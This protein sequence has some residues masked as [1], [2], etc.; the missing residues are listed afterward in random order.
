MNPNR[1][2]NFCASPASAGFAGRPGNRQPMQNQ[3]AIIG[4]IGHTPCCSDV[5]A[6]QNNVPCCSDVISG[7]I[8]IG[9]GSQDCNKETVLSGLPIAMAYVPWQSYGNI[10]PLQQALR[11]GTMF[12][13][14]DLEFAGR[15]C[16]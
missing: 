5:I 1:Q 6:A 9:S 4:N 15:R 12:R 8:I 2:N 10:Y 3:G 7:G 16:N 14:L 11:N 13:E